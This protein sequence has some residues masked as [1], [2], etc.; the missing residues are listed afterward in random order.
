M[1][2]EKILTRRGSL[3]FFYDFANQV[4]EVT[5]KFWRALTEGVLLD[6]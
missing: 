2:Q 1:T 6:P 4:T 5:K 3:I